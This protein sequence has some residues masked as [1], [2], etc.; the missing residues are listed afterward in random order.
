M[1][2]SQTAS[3]TKQKRSLLNRGMEW[4]CGLT[5]ETQSPSRTLKEFTEHMRKVTSLRQDPRARIGIGAGMIILFALDI[6]LYIFFS[7]GSDFG[8]LRSSSFASEKLIYENFTG[9]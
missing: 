6:F 8:L 5:D 3:V 7:T 9:S 4:F 2:S 1:D